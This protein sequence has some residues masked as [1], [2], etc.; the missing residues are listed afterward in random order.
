MG[1]IQPP[2]GATL[3]PHERLAFA[4]DVP[5]LPEAERWISTLRAKVGVYKVGLEL[6]TAVGRS[7]TDAVHAVG[8]RSFLD[9]KLHDIPAT[10]ARAA[11]VIADLGV[12][13]FT[14]HAAAGPEALTAV[15]RAVEGTIS[16]PLAVTV[17]TSLD[18][19]TLDAIG[20]RGT[21]GESV[22]RLAR[23]A[24]DCGVGGLVCSPRECA[25]LRQELG[26]RSTLVVPGIRPD[27]A[28]LGDQKRV[29]T[30]ARAIGD[31]ADLLVVGR[32]IRDAANPESTAEAIVAEI[33]GALS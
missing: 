32:P 30:P 9:L 11:R 28:A 22:L 4:L 31:G 5:T 3:K 29:A 33:S 21:T 8:A 13:Y 10:M 15:A 25:T 19:A 1:T 16:M 12:S 14:V 20:M 18:E 6:F 27:G 7:A 23:I 26:A 17:L 24:S 2:T